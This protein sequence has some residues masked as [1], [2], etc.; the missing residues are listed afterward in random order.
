MPG[1]RTPKE[2][3]S[4]A[5][6]LVSPGKR[7]IISD[8]IRAHR[9]QV[10]DEVGGRWFWTNW[11]KLYREGWRIARVRITEIEEPPR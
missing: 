5:W 7:E 10:L 9:K 11:R 4:I 3:A 1:S 2:K 8:F 6:A